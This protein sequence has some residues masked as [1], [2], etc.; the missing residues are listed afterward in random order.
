MLQL[1]RMNSLVCRF[2]S[3]VKVREMS[4]QWQVEVYWKGGDIV[5]FFIHGIE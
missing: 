5:F 4:L 3:V 1:Q 2:W